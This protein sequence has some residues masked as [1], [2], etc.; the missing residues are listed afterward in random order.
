MTLEMPEFVTSNLDWIVPA[1][2]LAALTLLALAALGVW[3][4]FGRYRRPLRVLLK[5]VL[6]LVILAGAGSGAWYLVKTRPTPPRRPAASPAVP[7]RVMTA[8]AGT[9]PVIVETM[10]AVLPARVVALRPEVTGRLI[11]K[12]STSKDDPLFVPG[13][14]YTAGEVLA[15]IEPADYD[16]AVERAEAEVA[17]AAAELRLEEGRQRVAKRAWGLLGAELAESEA[18][19]DLALRQPQRAI[20]EA[21]VSAARN[22]LDLA[23]LNRGRTVLRA[24]FDVVVKT[25]SSEVG[26][27]VNPSTVLVT[28]LGTDSFWVRVSIP[29]ARLRHIAVP[30]AGGTARGSA[31]EIVQPTDQGEAVTHGGRVLRLFGD[32]DPK[33]RMARLLVQVAD[34]L[35]IRS[36]KAA[37]LLEGAYVRVRI[38]GRELQ[39]AVRIP[40]RALREGGCVWIM[41]EAGELAVRPVTVGWST[42]SAALVSEGIR[43]GERVVTSLI[44]APVA[45]LKLRLADERAGEETSAA[46][47]QDPTLAPGEKEER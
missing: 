17:Q 25:V 47:R 5:V 11:P 44:S 34:P 26:Q 29:M 40:R 33:S 22:R 32:M 23:K 19:R 20:A 36:P 7:V 15:R 3:S 2:A 38:R 16:L 43:D 41:T 1:A 8:R 35:G 45:G 30:G 31:V 4:V 10:G 42:R 13:V 37:P 46:A 6:P 14:F 24:P 39:N 28:L 18:G 12:D 27:L 21:R 9:E